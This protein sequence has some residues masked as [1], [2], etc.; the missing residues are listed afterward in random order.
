MFFTHMEF[1]QLMTLGSLKEAERLTD[2]LYGQ[3]IAS[4]IVPWHEGGPDGELVFKVCVYDGDYF[5]AR[6]FMEEI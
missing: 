1:K 4:K 3:G 6:Y 5:R 2:L